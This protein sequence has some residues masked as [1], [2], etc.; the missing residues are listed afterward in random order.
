MSTQRNNGNGAH[1]WNIPDIRPAQ[2]VDHN[3]HD[4]IRNLQIVQA[5]R[6]GNKVIEIRETVYRTFGFSD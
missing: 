5:K 4:L 6:G 2:V 3:E 1:V